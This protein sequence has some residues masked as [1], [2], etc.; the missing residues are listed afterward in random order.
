MKNELLKEKILEQGGRVIERDTQNVD[1]KLEK[2]FAICVKTDEDKALFPIKVY[3]VTLSKT[4]YVGVIDE[5]GEKC[6]YP[7]DFFVYLD[8]SIKTSRLLKK[9]VTLSV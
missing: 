1:R 6:L 2:A 5:N 3:E 8:L 9:A 4:D 7:S